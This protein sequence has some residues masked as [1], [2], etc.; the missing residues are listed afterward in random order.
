M[1]F[2][3]IE[4]IWDVDL[5]TLPNIL[6]GRIYLERVKQ[7]VADLLSKPQSI[8][9]TVVRGRI[10]RSAVAARIGCRPAA[11][12]RNPLIR[13]VIEDAERKLA[14]SQDVGSA[15]G[16]Q[17]TLRMR[18]AYLEQAIAELRRVSADQASQ[19]AAL[20][21]LPAPAEERSRDQ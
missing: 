18:V 14:Q 21:L 3:D 13:A 5:N 9:G 7:V 10:V 16:G 12:S 19:I 20:Q 15:I 6:V 2:A 4:N 11:I 1:R 17:M 8:P